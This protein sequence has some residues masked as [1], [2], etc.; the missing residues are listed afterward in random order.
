MDDLFAGWGAFPAS[1]TEAVKVAST[2]AALDRAGVQTG[3]VSAWSVH[4]KRSACSLLIL[5]FVLL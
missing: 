2:V 5:G 4:N 1:P 3:L